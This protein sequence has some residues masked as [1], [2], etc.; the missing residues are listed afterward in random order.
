MSCRYTYKG[1]TYEVSEFDD[2]LRAMSPAEAAAFMPGVSAI[3]DAPFVQK[4]DG[5]L[6][7]ALKRVI[8]MAVESG[9][10]RVAFVTGAQAAERFD[11]SKQIGSVRWASKPDSN[12]G[13]LTVKD[14][15]GNTVLRGRTASPLKTSELE[16]FVGKDVAR[17]LIESQP[18]STTPYGDEIREL[19]GL[20]LKVGGDGM[21]DFY[22]TIVPTA[23]NALLKKVGGGRVEAT[24]FGKVRYKV[25]DESTGFS[26]EPSVDNRDRAQQ[27]ADGWNRKNEDG[28]GY[29]GM[30]VR[31]VV[32][33]RDEGT[34]PAFDITPA[35]RDAVGKG[36]PL[37]SRARSF[38]VPDSGPVVDMPSRT[39][40]GRTI[41]GIKIGD[42]DSV[43][44]A[45][46]D[47]QID[48]KRVIEAIKKRGTDIADQWN[49]YLKE[50]LYHGRTAKQVQDFT[51][52]ELRPLLT[53]MQM[54][55][56]SI[57][58]FEKYLH[59]RTAKERNEQMAK[60]NPTKPDMQDG[61]SGMLTKVARKYLA[62]LSEK[63]RRAYEALAARVDAINAST[64]KLMV[65]SGLET[66][67]TMAAWERTYQHYVPLH[68][69]EVEEGGLGTGQGYSVKGSSSKRAMGSK[70]D[71]V[72]ILANIAM[73]REKTIVRAEKARVGRA[74]FGLAVK[75]PNE[76]FWMPVAPSKLAQYSDA[77]KREL[78]AQLVN[79]GLDPIDAAGVVNEPVQRAVD[80]RTGL[81]TERINPALRSRDNVLAVRIDGEDRYVFFN[82]TDDRALRL[83][84]SMK[85]LDADQLGRVLSTSA[86]ISRY[87]A[88]VNTQ[89]NPI[90]GVVNMLRDTQGALINLSTTAIA[91]DQRAVLAGT[92]PAIRGIYADIR[93]R[94]DGKAASGVWADLWQQFQNDGGQTGYRDMWATAGDRAKSLQSEI[95]Q[96]TEGKVK[97]AGRALFAWLSDYNETLE[98]GVRLSAYKAALDKGISR[99][100]AASLA[101]NL[102]VNFNRKGQVTANAGALYAFFNAN[103]QGTA[104]LL[105][106]LKGP[107]GKKIVAGAMLLGT[108]QALALAAAGFGDEEPPQFVRERNIVIPTGGGMYITIPMPLGLHVLPSMAR[109]TTE[110]AL[111]GFKKPVQRLGLMVGLLA[112]TFNPIGSAGLSI[113]TI[114]PTAVDPL[115]ALSENRDWNG[116]PIARENLNS[117]QPSP[118]YLRTKDTASIVSKTMSEWFNYASGG[119]RFTPGMFSPTPD[120]LD[121]L[122]GQVGGGVAR[123]IIKV[124]Q[125]A[126]TALSGEELAPYKVPLLGRFYG[127]TNSSAAESGKYYE[128]LKSVYAHKSE[129]DGRR[130]AGESVAE[131]MRENPGSKLVPLAT[132]TT[133]DIDR[134]KDQKKLLIDRGAPT[135]QVRAIE[136]RIKERMRQ[137]NARIEASTAAAAG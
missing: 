129:M 118:G 42:R 22:D 38:N 9:A 93:A 28:T 110:W 95:E 13:K 44:Y 82:A 4:T 24:S 32:R 77:R 113:Q 31:A 58:D 50:E 96:I 99:E 106:T 33:A 85:N 6:A 131:Y 79:M 3:P 112:D 52:R 14:L 27:L 53:D 124:Q 100:Q 16:D 74:L 91:G 86:T 80:P 20:D 135:D 121:Y 125:T 35:M 56:V 29:Q 55:G 47:K 133:R 87:F 43:I 2:L 54:R 97:S 117:L 1:K 67:E 90:F 115:V 61:G 64:R 102:T 136:E 63:D 128:N 23:A 101:K 120:Q 18:T 57:A 7:L 19:S 36:L 130:K 12:T 65:D 72:D 51:V 76:E 104:R 71:V 75:N 25:V 15:H 127:D 5:W 37:F 114:A 98:N 40:A 126:G 10:D 89:W 119:T 109:I 122:A 116:R 8:G 26:Y 84:K 59:A 41:G 88:A 103:V 60:I 81:V 62:G 66:P 49:A 70:K 11:L 92:L 45:L 39:I 46:Q 107:M 111:S 123:E 34:Q 134:L 105:E 17:K 69:D 132:A 48:L 108:A 137:F 73:Q 78:E 68:R 94:R 30:E 21:K 83:V